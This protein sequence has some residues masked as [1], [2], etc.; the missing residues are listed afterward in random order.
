MA[1]YKCTLCGNIF[2][3]ERKVNPAENIECQACGEILNSTE[4]IIVLSTGKK[5]SN[6]KKIPHGAKV[7]HYQYKCKSC[8]HLFTLEAEIDYKDDCQACGEALSPDS[9]ML[10][11]FS[12][13]STKSKIKS[14]KPT[15]LNRKSIAREPEASQYH[16]KCK[17]CGH[18]F[19]LGAKFDYTGDCHSC[20]E[21]L[22]PKNCLQITAPLPLTKKGKSETNGPR[23]S[24]EV[25]LLIS[26]DK[27]DAEAQY[28]LGI[29]YFK[30]K[31]L[32][33][34]EKYFRL[35]AAQ[36]H[37]MAIYYL[38]TEFGESCP[39]EFSPLEI[40][41]KN[42]D[43]GDAES[44][45]NLAVH[46]GERN[47]F[48]AA[49]KYLTLA[50]WQNHFLALLFF[51]KREMDTKNSINLRRTVSSYLT[52]SLIAVLSILLFFTHSM[53]ISGISVLCAIGWWFGITYKRTF[54]HDKKGWQLSFF[55][56]FIYIFTYR[57]SSYALFSD[58]PFFLEIIL[59]LAAAVA[60][61]ILSITQIYKHLNFEY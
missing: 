52:V 41:I 18:T 32:I 43:S 13:P 54:E 45:Y 26:A 19:S 47:D 6:E 38:E 46:Y 3:A 16:Y 12:A 48:D 9:C 10:V 51:T 29:Y 50:A 56:M 40:L 20:G 4:R 21:P 37:E 35:A 22:T 24:P 53:L 44:Q 49:M 39:S 57:M 36:N 1:E 34:A 15:L 27:G 60:W 30:R 11:K 8:G 7:T 42:A 14:P 58:S 61:A 33:S 55:T 31:S 23:I 59:L 2:D 28:N 17:D 25:K 5:S